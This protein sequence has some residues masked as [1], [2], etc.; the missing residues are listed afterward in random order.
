MALPYQ[1]F[2]N[3]SSQPEIAV[4]PQK[5]K[6]LESFLIIYYYSLLVVIVVISEIIFYFKRLFKA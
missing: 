2:W 1:I 3:V 4:R 5:I 6:M